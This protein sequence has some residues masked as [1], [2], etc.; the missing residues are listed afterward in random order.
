[1]PPPGDGGGGDWL[2]NRKRRMSEL[3]ATQGA[4]AQR[5]QSA[6]QGV[7]L[8]AVTDSEGEIRRFEV[9][10]TPAQLAR[11]RFDPTRYHIGPFRDHHLP[12]PETDDSDYSTGDESIPV[13]IA[14]QYNHVPFTIPTNVVP[15][16]EVL[17]VMGT[18]GPQLDT[19]MGEEVP[20]VNICSIM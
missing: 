17:T 7:P 9:T 6:A 5:L 13:V 2:E 14:P 4:K 12:L 19:V 16:P 11:G 15:V 10:R 20:N 8:T 18:R 1:M 3:T